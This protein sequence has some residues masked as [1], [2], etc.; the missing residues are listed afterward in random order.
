MFVRW[1]T[2]PTKGQKIVSEFGK[3]RFGAALF[4]PD[5]SEWHQQPKQ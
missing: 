5:S 4:F 3:E 2:S 1:L